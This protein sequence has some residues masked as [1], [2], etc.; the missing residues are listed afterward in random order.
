[1][2]RL[3]RRLARAVRRGGDGRRARHRYAGL[4]HQRRRPR[5]QKVRR[6]RTG[7]R[8]LG[9]PPGSACRVIDSGSRPARACLLCMRAGVSPAQLL[10]GRHGCGNRWRGW[11]RPGLAAAAA[12]PGGPCAQV[13]SG[14]GMVGVSPVCLPGYRTGVM[15]N[16][17]SSD[18]G[19]QHEPAGCAT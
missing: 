11:R 17:P 18:V 19:I 4:P 7:P 6:Q 9:A 8:R 10:A 13:A 1:M 16:M 2:L 3:G 12:A 15:R 14:A 5:G